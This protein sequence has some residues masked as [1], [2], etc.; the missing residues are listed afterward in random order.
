[1]EEIIKQFKDELEIKR[2]NVLE[3]RLL[4]FLGDT[5]EKYVLNHI[6]EQN[7]EAYLWLEIP[8]NILVEAKLISDKDYNNQLKKEKRTYTDEGIDILI[9]EDNKFIY[10]QCKNHKKN[11]CTS[12]LKSYHA[13]MDIVKDVK[14]IKGIVYS[15]SKIS[16]GLVRRS[17]VEYIQLEFNNNIEYENYK[18]E[19]IYNIWNNQNIIQEIKNKYNRILIKYNMI[20]DPNLYGDNKWEYYRQEIELYIETNKRLPNDNQELMK[21]INFQQQH[22]NKDNYNKK[23]EWTIFID[24]YKEYINQ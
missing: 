23:H 2:N 22:C 11:I 12:S 3:A 18:K 10:V 24:K 4:K 6:K 5:Y 21:F 9:K 8:L 19:A 17:N 14:D 7:K 1:M 16:K 20:N 13:L 15:G